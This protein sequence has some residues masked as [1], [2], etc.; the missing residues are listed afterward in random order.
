MSIKIAVPSPRW[1]S[2]LKVELLQ[3]LNTRLAPKFLKQPQLE[4][5]LSPKWC[6]QVSSVEDTLFSMEEMCSH[7]RA[8]Q[9]LFVRKLDEGFRLSFR[10]FDYRGFCLV[11]DSEYLYKAVSKTSFGSSLSSKDRTRLLADCSHVCTLTQPK[12][13]RTLKFFEAHG[14]LLSVVGT[15]I[16]GRQFHYISDPNRFRHCLGLADAIDLGM[17]NSGVNVRFPGRVRHLVD[18]F[19]PF[20]RRMYSKNGNKRFTFSMKRLT[21]KH[22]KFHLLLHYLRVIPPG[23]PEK[24]YVKLIKVT[25]ARMFSEQMDQELP[26]GEFFPLFPEYTQAKLDSRFLHLRRE[27]CQFYFNLLQ[28]KALCAPVGRDMIDEA[29][30]KHC[31]SLC[32]PQDDL[33]EVP[34]EH[35][36]GLRE[37]GRK[38][39]KRLR[40]LYDPFKTSLPNQRACIEKGRHLGGNLSQLKEDLNVQLFSNHPITHLKDRDDERVRLEP[41]VIGLFGPPGSGKTTLV[42]DLIRSLG[43]KLFPSMNRE[44]LVYSRSCATDHWDGYTGQPIVVLDDFGQD[45]VH[46]VDIVEFENI[47]SVNDYVLPMAELVDKGQMFESPIIILTSNCQYGSNLC[48]NGSSFVEEPWAVWRRIT[49]PLLIERKGLFP[50]EIIPYLSIGQELVWHRKYTTTDS[51]QGSVPMNKAFDHRAN[52]CLTT[53]T[54]PGM[55]HLVERIFS[56]LDDRFNYHQFHIQGTWVQQISRKRIRCSPN[57]EEPLLWD[58]YVNDI[59]FPSC[60]SDWSL[61]A[62]FNSRPPESCPIVKAVALSEPLKVRMITAAEART[63]VLQPFQQALWQYLTEQPQFCLTNG[64]KAPWSEHD[65]FSDDTIPWIYRIETMIKQIQDRSLPGSL[66]LSG[67]Y[68][69]ATDNFPM[70]VTHAL[71]EGILSEIDHQPTIDWV[72]WECSSHE[73]HYPKGK[74][75]TQTSGQLMGSLISFPLLC[76]LNDYIVSY[77][78]FDSSSYLINGDDVVANGEIEKIKTWKAEAPRVGLSLSIGKNFIDPDFCTVNSQLFFRGKVLHTGKV[79]CQTRVGTTLS[80]CFEETQF[81]WGPEDWVKYEFLKRNL[82]ELRKTPRSLHLSKKKGGL[83]LIDSIDGTGLR[84][85][86]GLMKEV[87]LYDLLSKFDKSELIPG[88]SIRAVPIPVLRGVTAKKEA[89]LSG[90]V[91]MDRIRSLILPSGSIEVNG[92]MTHQ[93][94]YKFRRKV[95]S[96]FPAETA[97]HIHRIVNSGK[98]HIR[99]FPNTDFFEIDYLPIQQ[100]KSRFVLERAR[101]LCLDLFEYLLTEPTVHPLHWEG[102]ELNELPGVSEEWAKMKEIYH[103]RNLLTDENFEQIDLDVTEDVADWYNGIYDRDVVLK[104][105]SLYRLLPH[106]TSPIV[107][108]LSTFGLDPLSVDD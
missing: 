14:C 92:D 69:A 94:L 48:A 20:G 4:D 12:L 50:K 108:F 71:I 25:L 19:T 70:S 8:R 81:Y 15:C 78:G 46:R 53:K 1:A 13:L 103:D 82:L 49:L 26:D 30:Q 97:G 107:D 77:S 96:H 10:L 83:G 68:N 91:Q 5:V 42:Q 24:N 57:P 36:I 60:D 74:V 52:G 31:E 61:D 98:Y 11:L 43:R 18:A 65:S 56:E 87:Y 29:Y 47:V 41:Y 80:Y 101:Q 67:D 21:T 22:R 6:S 2:A 99:D 27:R 32:R 37:Y 54:I 90:K 55:H 59:P 34:E 79:S 17:T 62:Q 102:G 38:V 106:D 33:L 86:H 104:G 23:R 105:G 45:H 73:I 39:G 44:Q 16:N 7:D 35:L 93:D 75:G 88:T 72:R 9:T 3:R 84:Y 58:V 85:D 28:S 40:T 89:E 100:G 63:K 66:W 76:F 95:K 64:C 51:F